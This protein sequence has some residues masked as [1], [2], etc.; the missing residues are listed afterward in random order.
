MSYQGKQAI[1]SLISNLTSSAAY[2]YYRFQSGQA[3]DLNVAIDFKFWGST[4][5]SYLL[6]LIIFKI[7]IYII[8]SIMN[9]IITREEEPKFRDE[10]DSLINLKSIRNFYHILTLGIFLSIGTLVLDFPPAA[11]F[12]GILCS[13]FIASIVLDVSE[14]YFYHK[15]V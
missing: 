8:F 2:F 4:I 9:T 15:G 5:L 7:L 3:S 11:V 6:V 1:V 10:M 13:M 12:I 14:I